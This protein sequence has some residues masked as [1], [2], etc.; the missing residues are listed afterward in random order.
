MNRLKALAIFNTLFLIVH[1]TLSYM[2]QFKLI[3]SYDVGEIAD[4]YGALFT[5]AGV[6]FA[7]WGVIYT[8]LGAF[9]LYHIIIAFKHDSGHPANDDLSRI[10]GM[11]ILN[12]MATAAWLICWTSDRIAWSFLLIILQLLS[13]ATIHYR[14][15]ITDRKRESGSLICTQWPLSIYLGWVSVATIANAS[16]LLVSLN[17]KLTGLDQE[18]WTLAMIALTIVTALLMVFLRKNVSFGLVVI[19]ALYGIVLKRREYPSELYQSLTTAAWLG[20]VVTGLACLIQFILNLKYH[21]QDP[22]FPEAKYSSK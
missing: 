14:L 3:N 7:I 15:L 5:P 6:T 10:G 17:E 1:I 13:L 12:N 16:I 21:R 20:I 11:F 18:R 9:C 4:R 19:W 8:A 22:N 2:T